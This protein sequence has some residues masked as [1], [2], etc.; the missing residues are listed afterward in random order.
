MEGLRIKICTWDLQYKNRECHLLDLDVSI[1]S[2]AQHSHSR[3]D[4]RMVR[5]KTVL[6]KG[7]GLTD[8]R[9]LNDGCICQLTLFLLFSARF[10][11]QD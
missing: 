1:L 3:H 11:F 2:P 9:S 5:K 7:I 10:L 8:F 4:H 6:S